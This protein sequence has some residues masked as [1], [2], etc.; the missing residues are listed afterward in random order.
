[1]LELKSVSQLGKPELKE[2]IRCFVQ[3]S[4]PQKHT[5]KMLVQE[6]ELSVFTGNMTDRKLM[7]VLQA[8]WPPK[9]NQSFSLFAHEEQRNKAAGSHSFSTRTNFS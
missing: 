5:P 7:Q 2:S 9:S 4:M 1:M 3:S 6:A 8:D